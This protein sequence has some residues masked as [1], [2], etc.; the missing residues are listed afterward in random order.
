LNVRQEIRDRLS[1]FAT[2]AKIEIGSKGL[3]GYVLKL[4]EFL[5]PGVGFWKSL[6]IYFIELRLVVEQTD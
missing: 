6:A 1:G 2:T 3:E 5:A 4:G